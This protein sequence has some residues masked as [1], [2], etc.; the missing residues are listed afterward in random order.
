MRRFTIYYTLLFMFHAG[1]GYAQQAMPDDIVMFY[2]LENLFDPFDDSTTQDEE[3]TPKGRYGW[4]WSKLRVKTNA[5]AKTIVA[6]GKGNEPA[7]VGVCEVEN[8]LVLYRLVEQTPLAKIGYGIVHRESPDP[9]GI[10]VA[11]LYR[12]DYF[13]VLHSA[14]F[15]VYYDSGNYRTREILYAKG[16]LHELDT[17]HV[18]VTHWPSKLGGPVKSE[19]RRMRAAETVRAITDSIFG[20]NPRANIIVMGDFNDT[21]DSNPIVHGLQAVHDTVCVSCLHNLMLPLAVRGEGSLKYRAQWELI[22]L[23]FVSGNLLNVN[24]PI[25][26]TPA[27]VS[28][29][30]APFLLEPDERYLGEK[31]HRTHEAGKYKGGASDHLPILLPIKRSF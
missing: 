14:W 5:I 3:F 31:V 29:F 1:A 10:D 13:T 4:T 18:L 17:L 12:T 8:R 27:E 23:F 16:V 21:P 25:Y 2:N 7:L 20:V 28:I 30:H 9:R 19:P 15:R 24:E 26:C 6:A 11:L 22:D